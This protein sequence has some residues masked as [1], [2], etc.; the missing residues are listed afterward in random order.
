[1]GLIRSNHT[2]QR[3]HEFQV[4]L[5]HCRPLRPCSC[6]ACCVAAL[7]SGC[8]WVERRLARPVQRVLLAAER[9][10]SS[11]LCTAQRV[12]CGVVLATAVHQTLLGLHADVLCPLGAKCIKGYQ[13]RR[14]EEEVHLGRVRWRGGRSSRGTC[15]S[16]TAWTWPAWATSSGASRKVRLLSGRV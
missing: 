13:Y 14:R 5:A 8:L 9:S 12:W 15:S 2:H 10:N 3:V 4:I 6:A 1:M 11:R 7:L 16:T